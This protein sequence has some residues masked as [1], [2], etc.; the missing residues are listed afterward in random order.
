VTL[1]R[2]QTLPTE[3]PPLVGEVRTNCL[4]IEYITCS[5]QRIPTIVFSSFPD[6]SRYY[7]FQAA[8]RNPFQTHYISENLVAPGMEPGTS[9]SVARNSDHQATEQTNYWCDILHSLCVSEDWKWNQ[10]AD[11][12]SATCAFQESFWLV[13]KGILYSI[14]INVHISSSDVCVNEHCREN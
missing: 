13:R 7:F 8:E 10:A 4:R 11:I 2:E 14:L 5:P 1:V 3:W 6:L 9:G 12:P